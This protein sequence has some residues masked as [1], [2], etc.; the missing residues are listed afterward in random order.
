MALLKESVLSK[1][2]DLLEEHILLTHY[3]HFPN[4]IE[5]VFWNIENLPDS[6]PRQ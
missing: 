3:K 5:I 6:L 4:Q 1:A 2:L